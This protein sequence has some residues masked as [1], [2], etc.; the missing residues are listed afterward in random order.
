MLAPRFRIVIWSLVATALVVGL[1]GCGRS[2]DGPGPD[3]PEVGCEP[4]GDLRADLGCSLRATGDSRADVVTNASTRLTVGSADW[5]SGWR[6]IRVE[7]RISPHALAFHLALSDVGVVRGLGAPA[8]VDR[9]ARAAGVRIGDPVTAVAV[10]RLSVDVVL[11]GRSF[12]RVESVEDVP[13]LE[14][15]S[16]GQQRTRE[17]VRDVVRPPVARPAEAGW[18]VTVWTVDQPDPGRHELVRHELTI[19]GDGTVTE[20]SKTV[21]TGLAVPTIY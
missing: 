17:H 14:P 4:T 12:G 10:G 11:R 2:N 21:V 19:G 18:L 8:E 6:V 16:A 1:G 13:W 3:R 9:L 7:P 5:L 20:E 15:L